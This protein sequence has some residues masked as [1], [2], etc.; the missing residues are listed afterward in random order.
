ML[1]GVVEDRDLTGTGG[2]GDGIMEVG[3]DL[4]FCF[5][6]NVTNPYD[7]TMKDVVIYDNIISQL[8]LHPSWGWILKSTQEVLVFDDVITIVEQESGNYSITFN[9]GD[10]EPGETI[11]IG[12]P[13]STSTNQEGQQEF[14]SSGSYVLNTGA[15]VTFKLEGHEEDISIETD[16]FV[17]TI[18]DPN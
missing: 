11:R 12:Y 7:W 18:S 6:I 17:I 14:T 4:W 15:M 13:I 16:P 5:R 1:C 3:E 2:D 9:L 8:E 10:L